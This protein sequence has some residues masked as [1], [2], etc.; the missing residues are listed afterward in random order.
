VTTTDIHALVGAYALDAVDD[1]ERAAFV[2]HL[3]DC[4]TCRAELDELR[5][6]AARLADGTWSVPP[7]RLRSEVLAAIGRTRQL[8]PGESPRDARKAT[9]SRWRR[10]TAA[11]AAAVVLAGGAGAAAWTIQDQRVRDQRALAEAAEQREARTRAILAAPDM[12]VRTAPMRGGGK[13]TVASSVLRNAAVVLL[14]ADAPP[15]DGKAFQFWAIHGATPTDAGV[16][17]AG[18]AS[19]VQIIDGLPGSSAF[20]VTVE[21]AGGSPTPSQPL[22]ALVQLT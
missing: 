3:A 5:E 19:A 4:P 2:R 1:L 7:P 12:V 13:V 18:Q 22:A 16:L 17:A 10:Y 21:P 9:A 15:A 6:T 11:A 20:G 8:T 14:G